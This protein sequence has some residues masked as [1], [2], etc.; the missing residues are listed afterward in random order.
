M[1]I[2]GEGLSIIIPAYNEVESIFDVIQKIQTYCAGIDYEILVVDDG[3]TDGTAE[4]IQR[5]GI[6]VYK[7][8]SN[9]GYGATVKVGVREASND[10]ICITD[11]DG[12]YPSDRIPDLLNVLH[13]CDADMVVGTR[14]WKKI[15]LKR[16]FAKFIIHKFSE[17]LLSKKIP[18]MNSGLRI[19]RKSIFNQF[20]NIFPNGFSITSTMT[21]A[22]LFYGY[23]TEFVEIDYYERVGKSKI[24][25]I[26]DTLNFVQLILRTILYFDP[27]KI[28]LPPALLL[29]VGG[30]CLVILQIILIQNITSL[31]AI[32]L[33]SGMQLL[34]IGLLADMINRKL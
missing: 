28:F 8:P 11:A 7:N 33:F 5:E 10:L 3:S 4:L 16:R 6:K 19:F 23:R 31:T 1:G 14:P 27:L 26:K 17:L 24:H 32:I 20:L 15:E 12:T 34:A 9:L 29:L 2:E 18:D 30:F 21:M 22:F 13:E 25:P